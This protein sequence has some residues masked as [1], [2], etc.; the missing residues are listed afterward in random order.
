MIGDHVDDHVWIML[1]MNMTRD[2]PIPAS[3]KSRAP[4]AW[5]AS[6]YLRH[7][8]NQH[9]KTKVGAILKNESTSKSVA[10]QRRIWGTEDRKTHST[11]PA[12][13][14]GIQSRSIWAMETYS[15]W[16]IPMVAFC[17][18]NCCIVL[19]DDASL[20]WI[21]GLLLLETVTENGSYTFCNL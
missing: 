17:D 4:E 19:K 13:L 16:N 15:R 9:R 18:L 2:C 10:K 6:R 11:N 1:V 12:F 3:H 14:E 7:F 20:C 5:E 8:I 21:S